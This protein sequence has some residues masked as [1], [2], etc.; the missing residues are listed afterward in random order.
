MKLNK[1]MTFK[2]ILVLTI[3][4]LVMLVSCNNKVPAIDDLEKYSYENYKTIVLEVKKTK[5]PIE[6]VVILDNYFKK[7]KTKDVYLQDKDVLLLTRFRK[8]VIALSKIP[9]KK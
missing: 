6:R 2:T 5:D 3:S 4:V 8:K 9:K 1:Q 7:I